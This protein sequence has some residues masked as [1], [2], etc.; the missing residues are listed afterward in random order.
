MD[1]GQSISP[2]LELLANGKFRSNIAVKMW[3]TSMTFDSGIYAVDFLKKNEEIS[4]IMP[5]KKTSISYEKS[6]F[7]YSLK[8][9]CGDPDGP[10]YIR[11]TK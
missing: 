6:L 3:D 5:D 9:F 11:L 2:K 8:M 10:K 7:S 4:L 1:E